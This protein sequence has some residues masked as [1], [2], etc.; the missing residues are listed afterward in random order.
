[1]ENNETGNSE[2]DKNALL[3]AA[4][5]F[6]T[7][8]EAKIQATES[9]NTSLKEV[10]GMADRFGIN[11]NTLPPSAKTGTL[12]MHYNLGGTKFNPSTFPNFFGVLRENDF[13]RAGIES[14]RTGGVSKNRNDQT[15]E[16]FNKAQREF[17]HRQKYGTWR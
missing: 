17:E 6:I 5:A 10:Q 9:I 1:M 13:K 7:E 2:D 15:R 4:F 3:E 16:Q 12:D 14:H 11:F 8:T